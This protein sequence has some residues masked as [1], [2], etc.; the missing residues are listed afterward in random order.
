MNTQVLTLANETLRRLPPRLV[1]STRAKIWMLVVSLIAMC[2][3]AGPVCAQTALGIASGKFTINTQPTFLLGVSYFDVMGWRASDLD[4]LKAR[5]FNLVRIFLDWK[6]ST[7]RTRSHFNPDGSMKNTASLVDFVRACAARGIIV[8]ATILHSGSN[9]SVDWT[10][11]AFPQIAVRN[12]IRLLG[13]ESNVFFDLVNEHNGFVAV[14]KAWSDSHAVMKS[15]MTA[16]RQ[17]SAGEILT[18]SSVSMVFNGV[19]HIYR[20]DD[21]VIAPIADEEFATGIDVM[22]PH[23]GRESNWYSRTG[24]RVANLRNFISSRGSPAPVYFQEEQRRGTGEGGGAL[25]KEEFFQAASGAKN[26]GAG[27]WIFHTLAGFDLTTASF[28][29]RLDPVENEIVNSLGQVVF[30]ST[31][32]ANTP[33]SVSLTGPANGSS[34]TAPPTITAPANGATLSGTSATISWNSVSGAASYMVRCRDLTGTTPFDSRNTANVAGQLL[35]ID[36]YAATSITLKVV[37]GHSYSF[38]IHSAKSTFT[39]SDTTTYSS[40]A[41]VQFSMGAVAGVTASFNV[42]PEADTYV[43]QLNPATNYGSAP[44]INVGG[45]S[46]GYT[47]VAYLRFNVSG[48]PVGAMVTDARLTLV[49]MNPGSGGTLRKFLPT[50]SQWTESGPTWNNPLAGADGSGALSSLGLV[51]LGGAYVFTNLAGCVSANGRV[52]F[53]IRSSDADGAGY[54]TK[55]H[56]AASQRPVLRITYT[57]IPVSS[58]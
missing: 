50:T 49:C 22:S 7:N 6:S 58:G 57:T 52:T 15:L 35:Y 11:S 13:P 53:V 55:E 33:P 2:A 25:P 38:W 18:Y 4:A 17:E 28:F 40:P 14:G 26:A 51:N 31:A 32:P 5:R 41:E 12:A 30:G 45:G 39:Y 34:F 9:P 24:A 23:C 54:F 56:G 3:F 10:T 20:A 21:T 8:D 27:A 29:A 46:T 47:R 48:L 43:F 19:G 44:D 16:A 1:E 36:K 37:A 42:A